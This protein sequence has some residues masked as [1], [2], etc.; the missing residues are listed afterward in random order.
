[1]GRSHSDDEE[2]A[3]HPVHHL[4]PKRGPLPLLFRFYKT[5]F[6]V[7]PWATLLPQQQQQRTAGGGGG[8]GGAQ[9]PPS[10][11]AGPSPLAVPPPGVARP[12]R[13][14]L[15]LPGPQN[16][17]PVTGMPS[18]TSTAGDSDGGGGPVGGGM[19]LP[20]SAAATSGGKAGAS[21]ADM[22]ESSME[23]ALEEQEAGGEGSVRGCEGGGWVGS[24]E[25]V[26]DRPWH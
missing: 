24:C 1:M 10:H 15:S 3:A 14:P 17:T 6:S 5:S 7:D 26:M 12:G 19:P 4:S 20:P 21:L 25:G 16:P 2:R 22:F 13:G 9:R 8:G 11:P 18:L 23:A